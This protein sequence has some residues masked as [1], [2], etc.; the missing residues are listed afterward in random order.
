[1]ALPTIDT[2][3]ND[4][5]DQ[6]R[7]TLQRSIRGGLGALGLKIKN[8][9]SV[10]ASI[11]NTMKASYNVDQQ[12]LLVDA[13]N[14]L[15]ATRKDQA[16]AD[17]KAKEGK[18]TTRIKGG[19]LQTLKKAFIGGA[20]IG[21]IALVVKYWDQV[22]VGLGV[23]GKTLA[24]LAKGIVKVGTFIVK[25]IDK[26]GIALFAIWSGK[27]LIA[28]YGA[29]KK[30][31]NALVEG[32]KKT[33]ESL[34]AAKEKF[35]TVAKGL[36]EKSTTM[37]E[38]AKRM[39]ARIADVSKKLFASAKEMAQKGYEKIAPH[40]KRLGLAIKATSM[41]M[42]E[43]AKPL[44]AQAKSKIVQYARV[45]AGAMS[46]VGAAIAAQGAALM[47]ALIAAA[48]F[49]AIAA[50][51][52]LALY[53]LK[54]AFDQMRQ[55]FKETGSVSLAITEGLSALFG[56]IV[57]FVPDLLKSA[58]SWILG[59]LGFDEAAET[60]D[61]FSISDFLQNGLSSIFDNIRL[62][63]MKAVNGIVGVVNS[64]LDFI[65]GFGANT[66]E[67]PFDIKKETDKI[68]DKNLTR[69][70]AQQSDLEGDEPTLPPEE[71]ERLKKKKEKDDKFNATLDAIL[72][73]NKEREIALGLRDPDPIIDDEPNERSSL[74]T[75][76]KE[77]K[78]QEIA[79]VLKDPNPITDGAELN[80]RSSQ[81]A[82]AAGNVVVT[83]IAPTNVNAPTS[84]NVSSQTNVTPTASRS[85]NRSR[86]GRQ[87]AP[88]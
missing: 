43:A 73:E 3:T 48:P 38:G 63:F 29:M 70:L 12:A 14:R 64:A 79:V 49:V 65:P 32:Y 30:G 13:E 40:A 42:L 52:A 47:P 51:V 78:E 22:K 1:M 46:A 83:T 18:L 33:K 34:M 21:A 71:V 25:H 19:L 16:E 87:F 66:I 5:A 58:T 41:R 59:K 15:E 20:I 23:L 69:K 85:R 35:V 50:G 60:L 74:D 88:A 39:G 57:G 61:S 80:E 62:L 53:G 54:E 8:Q 68:L 9:T 44:I 55:T 17:E 10:L 31:V 37:V 26:I 24:V 2:Q 84:T 56:T 6:N 11:A 72:A 81:A 7:E 4:N 82:S 36:K 28:A 77:N 67:S 76:G 75:I 45:L 86:R 27:K